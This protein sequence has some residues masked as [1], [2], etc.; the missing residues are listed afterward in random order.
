MANAYKVLGQLSP[1][2]NLN[3]DLYT[4][5]ATTSTVVSTMAVCNRG[6]TTTYR[7]SVR[8]GGATLANTHYL[9]F[10]NIVDSVDTIFLTLG[11]TLSTTDV[12]TVSANN[13]NVTFSLFGTE[14]T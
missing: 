14:I 7:V 1:G 12:V 2:S 11:L 5:P 4:V 13:S 10:D 6:N 8:P 3:F 9:I